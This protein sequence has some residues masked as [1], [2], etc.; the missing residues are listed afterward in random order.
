MK[1]LEGLPQFELGGPMNFYDENKMFPKFPERINIASHI[2]F[3]ILFILNWFAFNDF[4]GSVEKLTI[5]H[6]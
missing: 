3:L 6:N 2:L 1:H 5:F 4:N